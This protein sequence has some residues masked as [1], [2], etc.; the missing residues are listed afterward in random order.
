MFVTQLLH[1]AKA[2]RM[3]NSS[4]QQSSREIVGWFHCDRGEEAYHLLGSL[5][6]RKYHDV[7]VVQEDD[8]GLAVLIDVKKGWNEDRP[9]DVRFTK[10]GPVF[11]NRDHDK[12]ARQGRAWAHPDCY[13]E[14]VDLPWQTY[15]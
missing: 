7:F 8:Y 10:A 4:S 9:V 11:T 6:L 1:Y 3:R 2:N 13:Q 12:D 14:S 15:N 5:G